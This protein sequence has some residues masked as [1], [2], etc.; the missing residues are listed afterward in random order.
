MQQ[1]GTLQVNSTPTNASIYLNDVAT[2]EFTN[3]T[4][5]D[6]PVGEYNVTVVK[7]G[8][9][10]QT[11]TVTLTKDATELVDFTLV[12]Q[13]GTLQVNSTPAGAGIYLNDVATGELT[14]FTFTDKPVGEYNVTVVKD[15]YDTQTE[16]VTL[17]KD[18][19]ELVA[20]TLVQQVGT[21]QV[22]ST[23]TNASIY[24]NDIATGEFTNF[25]FDN[26]PVGE[27]NVTVVKDGYDSQTETVTLTKDATEQV[28]FTLVQQTG[29]LQVN[30]TPSNASIYL[31]DVA[32]GELT[33]FTFDNK[34]VGEYNV[35]VVKDGY[36][37]QTETV[38]LTKDAR[39]LVDF[40][41]VQQV[42]TLQVNSTPNNA[43]IYLNDVATG[44]LT[45]F[46]FTD[47][48]VGEYNVTV[49]KAG[50]DTLNETVILTKDATESVSFTLVQQVGTLQVNSTPTNASIYLNDVAT[51]EFTNFTFTDKPVGEYNVTV[52]K[53]GYDSQ[54]E[55]VTLTKDATELVDFTLVQ[56]TGTVQVNS[57]PTNA[58][59]YLNDVAT[60]EF[61]NFT[62][63]NKPV[64]EYN[65]TVVKDGY[66]SQRLRRS[67]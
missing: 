66:D 24:L 40:T 5:S 13:D 35:T 22:N 62:F 39:E 3:F 61:T 32:T 15:G 6:K 41:L 8:Y 37:S 60:G 54:S 59:I 28:S 67:L 55:T 31:N 21:L 25:T 45:N 36:D 29:T 9:D 51:G 4:F 57:T 63:D 65:V 14:N 7:D 34:P 30:S 47:K 11:E 27:Y 50:Y 48:P 58:S 49:V 38:T 19:T 23:P 17:R 46:T 10:T 43:S 1:V 26:K 20:F 18:A 52:V 64:G 56:Q 33:N 53:D 12:Q 42:G 2:G 16:M 44:E